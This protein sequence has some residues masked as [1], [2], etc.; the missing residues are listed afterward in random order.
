MGV[1]LQT[2]FTTLKMNYAALLLRTT[3]LKVVDITN[4]IGYTNQGHF[5][6]AFQNPFQ[7]V[8]S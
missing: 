7:N 4:R 8:P 6:R 3:S 5:F 1:T 2:Y